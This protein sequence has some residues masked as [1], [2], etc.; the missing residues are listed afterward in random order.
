VSVALNDARS[1]IE[2]S[3]DQFDLI[4]FS[5]LDSHTTTS[6]FTNIR[7]DNYVYTR[8]A[9]QRARQ[10]L[11]PDGLFVVKFQVDNPWISGRLYQLMQTTFGQNPIQFQTDL[12]GFDSSGRFFVAGSAVRLSHATSYPA[13]AAYLATHGNMPMQSARPTTDD[14]PYFYQH[15][16]GLPMSVILVS[17][18]VLIVFGWFLRQT[19]GEGGRID[20]H[21]MFLG[22]GF[23]LLEAQIVSKM[24][25]LFGTTWVVNAV[26]V[27]GLLCLIVGANLVYGALPRIPLWIAY[28]GLFASLVVMYAVP[29]QKLF[30]ESWTLR[31]LLATLALCTPVF[32]AGI[33]FISS[34]ARAGF[35][36]SA[37][38]SNLFGSLLGGLLESS[39]LWFGLK[40]LT[41]LAALLYVVSAI[42]LSSG[43]AAE[44]EDRA[45]DI[46]SLSVRS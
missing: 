1:Y 43:S 4:V 38:G 23:M 9:L 21:F 27:S 32:F 41:I 11:K 12:G 30:Y 35:R 20:L 18:A 15:E 45:A 5:L 42:F 3:H 14:W 22:A 26:V 44:S 13:L 31:A 17:V 46:P 8:E 25:L 7:I 6:H 39:S 28:A 33:I 2:N 29:L 40:S 19:S 10:L 16:P 34:F 37:L 24:A 36:G